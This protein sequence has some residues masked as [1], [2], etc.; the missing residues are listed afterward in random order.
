MYGD[1]GKLVLK[2][3]EYNESHPAGML[4]DF[5]VSLGSIIGR[6]PHFAVGDTMHYTNEF[7]IRVGDTARSRK[8]TGR[9]AMDAILRHVDPAWYSSRIENGFGSGEA[10]IGR[11]RDSFEQVIRQRDNTFKG[12]VVPGVDDKRLCIREGEAASILVLASKPDS[13]ADIILRDG[14]DGKVLRNV[15]K[16]NSRDGI[17][18]SA[19][20]ENPH[21]S[22]SA[23][24]TI[25]ELRAKMPSGAEANGF[26]NRFLYYVYASPR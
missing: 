19:K 25:S 12:L 10:I 11:I 16:G 2:A 7:F 9:D 24:T 22:I 14:W 18:S 21:L 5:L 26:G 4:V 17:N 13:R 20:C 15:V 6:S 1:A 8:G 23:D 3:S